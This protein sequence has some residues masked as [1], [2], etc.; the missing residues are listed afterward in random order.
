MGLGWIFHGYTLFVL[1]FTMAFQ[2][3]CR[4]NRGTIGRN[5]SLALHQPLPE[6]Y[7]WFASTSA[8]SSSPRFF[9]NSFLLSFV[10]AQATL[11]FVGPYNSDIFV[12]GTKI[13]HL[14]LGG[15]VLLHDRPVIVLSVAANLRSGSNTV[16]LEASA[17]DVFA[18]KIVPAAQGINTDALL[19]SDATWK[20]ATV[21][22]VG[23][24]QPSFDDSAWD[25]V[26]S[27]GSIE[28]D[29]H[30]FQGNFDLGMYQWPGYEGL[31]A[32]LDHVPLVAS[33]V[34]N[35][36]S[37]GGA[38]SDTSV[39]TSA[40]DHEDFL[41]SLPSNTKQSPSVTLDFGKE[42]SGRLE[43]AS[44]SP[45]PIHLQMIFGESEEEATADFSSLSTRSVIVPSFSTVH[46][47]L[48]AFR[49]VQILFVGG[50]QIQKFAHIQ[51]DQVFRNLLPKGSF[52]SS[53]PVI[54]QI[55]N[56]ST[57]TAQLGMQAVY[58][59]APKRDRNPFS[60][61]LYVAARTA[62]VAFGNIQT[63][64]DTLND[65]LRRVCIVE[66]A[67]IFGGDI[68]CIP[69][70]NAWWILDLGDQYRFSG[71]FVYLKSN[72]NNLVRILDVMTG[73]LTQNLFQPSNPSGIIF[74]DW[75]PGM[76]QFGAVKSPDAMKI[77]TFVYYRAFIE[78]AFLLR[79]LGEA[80]L[81]DKY[82]QIASNVKSAAIAAYLD[83]SKHTFGD[84][85]QTNAMAVYSGVS[86][87]ETTSLVFSKVLSKPPSQP[88]SPYFNYFVISAMA[89]AGHR[90]E[91]LALV[92]QHWGSMLN[93]GATTFWE[94]YDPACPTSINFHAC[95]T[96]FFNSVDNQGTDRY[97]VSLAHG[98]A[99]GPGA[100]LHE[101]ILGIKFRAPGFESVEIRPDLAGL[102]WARGTEE[103]PKGI[104]SIR[105]QAG[106]THIELDLPTGTDTYVSLPTTTQNPIVF[107]NGVPLLGN[108]V[109]N[110]TRT[111]IHL[112]RGSVTHF[113][114]QSF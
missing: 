6:Q 42:V 2:L 69:S 46:G 78:A 68:N 39:L 100:W 112:H 8:D 98:W 48:T 99:S 67:E 105:I 97:F 103:T 72:R 62:Q 16:A 55:W 47:P 87:P 44:S 94:V 64:R 113:D 85:M 45:E 25:R 91:A 7:I 37:N 14:L 53:D 89:Q 5:P 58:W 22:P 60:G 88:V 73:E 40:V 38:F 96:N 59:D 82:Q 18:I 31:S 108:L 27:F 111:M 12:N 52:E 9:R 11:Y 3:G 24:E 106:G 71:D 28:S 61:D 4:D 92:H 49:F 66:A 79:Q 75:S 50:P 19:L 84:R 95:L 109:E 65:L 104:I 34:L 81:A 41:V 102:Q 26:Q 20:G 29:F 110:K 114:L 90:A 13:S 70:Y 30:H 23:W 101:E 35:V 56:V 10:P 51:A 77:T 76:I 80:S 17:G 57:Y 43:I 1:L 74:A 107:V 93:A 86:D 83:S 54:N 63:I 36:A 21:V 33:R 15:P 32:L